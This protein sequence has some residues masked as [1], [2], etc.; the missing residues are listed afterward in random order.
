MQ[1]QEQHVQ[2]QER[3]VHHPEP[4]RVGTFQHQR[5][6]EKGEAQVLRAGTTVHGQRQNG[7][8]QLREFFR[9]LAL[10]GFNLELVRCAKVYCY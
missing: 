4:E 8:Q 2:H 5:E 7:Q 6:E 10:D 1:Q 9:I 3:P